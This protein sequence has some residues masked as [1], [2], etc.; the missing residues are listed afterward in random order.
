[1][2][3]AKSSYRKADLVK[4]IDAA[5]GAPLRFIAPDGTTIEINMPRGAQDGSATIVD[6]GPAHGPDEFDDL[7]PGNK[8]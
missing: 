1:M 2:P 5:D 6:A 4:A 3:A 8:D 7:L